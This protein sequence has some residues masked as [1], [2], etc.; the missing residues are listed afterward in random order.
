MNPSALLLLNFRC[1]ALFNSW[2]SIQQLMIRINA[3]EH[4]TAFSAG[5]ALQ[6]TSS[7]DVKEDLKK[8]FLST[9]QNII[10]Y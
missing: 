1:V 7:K 5:C 4:F 6:G 10:R 3:D 8:L 2:N 9:S